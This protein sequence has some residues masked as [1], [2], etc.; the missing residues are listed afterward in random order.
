MSTSLCPKLNRIG[1]YAGLAFPRKA[2]I[3]ARIIIGKLFC[4]TDEVKV[5]KTVKIYISGKITG[6]ELADAERKFSDCEKRLIAKN[7]LPINP[8]KILP[9]KPELT[10]RDYMKAD[11][12]A[13]FDCDT[14][15]M[16]PCWKDSKGAKLER[17]IAEQ[18]GLKIFYNENEIDF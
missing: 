2:K 5:V 11:I 15:L 13:L 1:I 12:A 18:I 9:F 6:L 14:I 3:F 7:I 8:M 4:L 16:L 10:W 17:I